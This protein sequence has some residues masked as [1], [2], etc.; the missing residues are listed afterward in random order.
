[1]TE[2]LGENYEEEI[3]Y[4]EEDPEPVTAEMYYTPNNINNP[5]DF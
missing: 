4:I 3:A 2:L 1:M 5:N